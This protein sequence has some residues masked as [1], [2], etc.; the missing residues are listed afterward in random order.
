LLDRRFREYRSRADRLVALFFQVPAAG[1]VEG[2]DAARLLR[3]GIVD[4]ETGQQRQSHQTL[5]R[6]SEV[7]AYHD[8]QPVHLAREGKW[9]TFQLF[10]V[11]EF[12]GVE[13][14]E[15]DRDG[16]GAGDPGRGVVIGDIH[17]LHIAARDHVAL[18]RTAV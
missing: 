11:L 7:A 3:V 18:R 1:R 16:R 14:G 15:F 10:V 6:R 2:N 12:D 17:I 8:G 4:V 13:P 5:H 9:H